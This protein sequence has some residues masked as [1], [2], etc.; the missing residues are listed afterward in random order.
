MTVDP[1]RG[2]FIMVDEVTLDNLIYL[3]ERMIKE[4]KLKPENISDI[5]AVLINYWCDGKRSL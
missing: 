1:P 2:V 5:I 4:Y 3:R